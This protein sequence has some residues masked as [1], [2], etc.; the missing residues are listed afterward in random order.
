[1]PA[2]DMVNQAVKIS[3]AQDSPFPMD[4]IVRTPKY[5]QQRIAEEDWF[6]REIVSRGKLLYEKNDEGV[7]PE[8][9][10]RLAGRKLPRIEQDSSS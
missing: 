10:G 1:M 8:S 7:G 5:L 9:R 6:L 4:L 3:L 2:S